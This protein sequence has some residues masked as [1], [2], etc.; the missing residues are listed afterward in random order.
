MMAFGVYIY[1]YTPVATPTRTRTDNGSNSASCYGG[2]LGF[3]VVKISHVF[4]YL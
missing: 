2:G 1:R 4:V 3:A